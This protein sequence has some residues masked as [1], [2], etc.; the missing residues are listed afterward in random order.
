MLFF[1]AH[2]VMCTSEKRESLECWNSR[3]Q[4]G[5]LE[6]ST[7]N[8][9]NNKIRWNESEWW[10]KI[11][12]HLKSMVAHLKFNWENY[13]NLPNTPIKREDYKFLNLLT[14]ATIHWG[15]KVLRRLWSNMKLKTHWNRLSLLW[16]CTEIEYFN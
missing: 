16:T 15:R 7:E 2:S 10:I 14:I 6:L 8:K 11:L 5:P 13:P 12:S 4:T 3:K 9:W 1:Q